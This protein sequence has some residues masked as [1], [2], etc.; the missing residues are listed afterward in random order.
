MNHAQLRAFHA[1]AGEGG[2]TRAAA[3][4]GVTQPTLSGQ[5]A[6]LEAAYGV[7]LFERRGRGIELTDL[8]AGL[9]DVTRRL[10]HQT[11]A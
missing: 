1:V 3:A 4:L 5:V 9:F 8:G 6:E 11:T 2:F 7:R 10:P